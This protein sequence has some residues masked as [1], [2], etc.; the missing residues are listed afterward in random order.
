MA[1]LR[2]GASGES[3]AVVVSSRWPQMYAV[4]LSVLRRL[5]LGKLTRLGE[6][7][8]VCVDFPSGSA[9]REAFSRAVLGKSE[10]QMHDYWIEQ[11][12]TGGKLPP[13]EL[14]SAG[15]V[16]EAVRGNVGTIGYIR[17]PFAD[18]ALPSDV[19]VLKIEDASGARLP[20]EPG[21]AIR[22]DEGPELREARGE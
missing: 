6:V 16:I 18:S 12:L 2:I 20:G 14:R 3:V 11:A 15:A 19:R 22:L 5:Y 1:P 4:S 8:V 7:A 21:Y 13:R 17:W 9:E 10:R